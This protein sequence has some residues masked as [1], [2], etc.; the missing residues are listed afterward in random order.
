MNPLE[1]NQI[2]VLLR[3]FHEREL[4]FTYFLK[5]FVGNTISKLLV[6]YNSKHS[7][8]GHSALLSQLRLK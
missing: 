2:I 6:Y 4:H 5:Q 1:D 8:D 7:A 3:G